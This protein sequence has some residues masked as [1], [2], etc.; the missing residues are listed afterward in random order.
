MRRFFA[1]TLLT[2]IIALVFA[3]PMLAAPRVAEGAKFPYWGPLISCT[4][5][6]P[7]ITGIPNPKDAKGNDIPHCVS[8][9][10]LL[11][12]LQNVFFFLLTLA[13]VVIAPLSVLGGALLMITSAGSEERV[14]KGRSVITG[15]V[16][17]ILFVLSAFL[18]VNTFM[19]FLSKL[20]TPDK[21]VKLPTKWYAITCSPT[22]GI[23]APK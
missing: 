23:T 12:T 21:G 10:D 13:L 1:G 18:I 3:L 16:L 17:G 7:A 20:V 11:A 22:K 4:G 15:T 19:F 2:G 6:D 9:C 14:S 5:N 8:I